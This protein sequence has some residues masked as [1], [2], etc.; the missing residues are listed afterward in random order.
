[1]HAL[2]GS[3]SSPL[4][5]LHDEILIGAVLFFMMT[6]NILPYATILN[7]QNHYPVGC[8]FILVPAADLTEQ[9]QNSQASL[10][11]SKSLAV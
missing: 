4:I 6:P 8:S 3:L 11:P 7:T 10:E 9:E 2:Q 5:P 1:M